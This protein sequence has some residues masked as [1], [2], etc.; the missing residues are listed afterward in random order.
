MKEEKALKKIKDLINKNE[1]FKA[2]HL[3][4]IIISADN[5]EKALKMYLKIHKILLK[6]AKKNSN[7]WIIKWLECEIEE[8][9]NKLNE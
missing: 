1:Y 3:C 7:R 5:N 6:K 4:E 8:T 2:I 9:K